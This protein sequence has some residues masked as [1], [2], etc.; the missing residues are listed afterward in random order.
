MNDDTIPIWL[1]LAAIALVWAVTGLIEGGVPWL[2][3]L[4]CGLAL[5]CAV[6]EPSRTIVVMKTCAFVLARPH[7]WLLIV[8]GAGLL[9]QLVG[10]ELAL[11]MAGD[12]LA[13]VELVTAVGLISAKARLAPLLTAVNARLTALRERLTAPVVRVFRASRRIRIGRPCRPADKDCDDAAGWA[14]A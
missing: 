10:V 6:H 11:F 8:V 14:F 9:W 13:Y 5:I 7:R 2:P 12:V 4:S 1:G 3:L